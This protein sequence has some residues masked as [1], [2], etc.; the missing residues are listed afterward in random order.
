VFAALAGLTALAALAV[1]LPRVGAPPTPPVATARQGDFTLT[2]TAPRADYGAGDV[3]DVHAEVRYDGTADTMTVSG[4]TPLV[5][6]GIEQQGGAIQ[7]LSVGDANRRRCTPYELRKGVPLTVG[8]TKSGG[9]GAEDPNAD[10]YLAY[11]NDPELRLPAGTWRVF[12]I[13][14]FSTSTTT[15][16]H[17]TGTLTASMTL[18][19]ASSAV[20]PA[21]AGEP[22]K[23]STEAFA[24]GVQSGKLA[25]QT[26][27]VDGRIDPG[28][29]IPHATCAPFAACYMGQLAGVTP[30]LDVLSPVLATTESASTMHVDPTVAKWAWWQQPQP[31]VE[32]DLVLKVGEDSTIQY[33]GRLTPSGGGLAWIPAAAGRRDPNGTQLDDVMLVEGWLTGIGGFDDCSTL[34]EVSIAAGFPQRYCGNPAWIVDSP[35]DFSVEGIRVQNGAYFTFA[36]NAT[37]LSSTAKIVEPRWGRYA[38]VRRLEDWCIDRQPTCWQWEIVGRLT[39]A[40]S[41]T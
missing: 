15:D 16:C 32:G 27:L 21:D 39:D 4:E 9:W 40:T 37:P 38:V 11:F 19:V 26:V 30:A 41:T 22:T 35:N 31:P 2:I 10:F 3:I 13:A 17:D 25:G 18:R 8:Y 6:F 20:R 33:L 36:P 14:F 7:Q 12:A 34:S 24:A 28:P 1:L 5:A 23:M 29:P